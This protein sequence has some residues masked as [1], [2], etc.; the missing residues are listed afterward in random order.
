M[1]FSSMKHLSDENFLAAVK[2]SYK[3]IISETKPL[4]SS[5]YFS[6]QKGKTNFK[7]Y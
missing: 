3:F 5:S 4:F 1:F 2:P 7:P 6:S